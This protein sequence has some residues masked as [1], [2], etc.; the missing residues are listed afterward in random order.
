MRA[1]IKMSCLI[2][3]S[4]LVP[5][6]AHQPANAGDKDKIRKSLARKTF[7]AKDPFKDLPGVKLPQKLPDEPATVCNS[8]IER[9]HWPDEPSRLG[10]RVYSC[11]LEGVDN[12]VIQSTRRP[13]EIE[14]Q[15]W[16]NYYKPWVG[17]GF[18]R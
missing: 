15:K 4:L 7:L 1:G 13:N 2:V 9:R 12:I 8:R 3:L 14:Y 5:A 10:R 17:D 11:D 16:K 18:D 6:V